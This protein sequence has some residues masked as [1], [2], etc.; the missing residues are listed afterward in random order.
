[1]S[2]FLFQTEVLSLYKT[3]VT[4]QPLSNQPTSLGICVRS[5]SGLPTEDELLLL[6]EERC[7]LGTCGIV[8]VLPANPPFDDPYSVRILMFSVSIC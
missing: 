1:M 4:P 6:D 3:K 8:F 5:I 2:N 7:M